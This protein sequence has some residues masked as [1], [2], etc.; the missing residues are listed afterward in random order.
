MSSVVRFLFCIT[1][2]V[3]LAACTDSTA[4]VTLTAAIAATATATATTTPTPLPAATA[5]PQPANTPT[6][7]PVPTDPATPV[8][9]ATPTATA[10]PEPTPTP[11]VLRTA[12]DVAESGRNLYTGELPN[13]PDTLD[14]RA[15]ICKISNF[16]ADMVRPQ[17]GLNSADIIFEHVTEGPIT[18]FSAIF[19]GKTPPN[20]GPIRSARL[21]DLELAVMYDT[22]LCFSGASI[23]VTERLEQ[24]EFRSRLIRSWYPGYY[25]TGA[26]KP[27]EHTFYADP[28]GFYERFE[29]YDKNTPPRP[30]T[31]MDF[32]SATPEGGES[33]EFVQID[34]RGWTVV[35]WRWDEETGKYWRWADGEPI[36]DAND[37]EQVSAENVVIVYA[38]HTLDE[39]ICEHQ[40][41]DK[42]LAGST[43]IHLWGE[44]EMTLLRDGQRFDGYWFRE[45]PTDMLT[46]ESL[47]NENLAL[48]IGNTWVQLVPTH[49]DGAVSFDVDDSFGDSAE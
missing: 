9:T 8:P 38:I 6:D 47:D 42:C 39:T 24:P 3:L 16:P 48:Q 28:A 7:T 44:G 21:V 10:T 45:D 1:L 43:L 17:S 32:E 46:F 33:A 40:Q 4:D 30:T 36:I 18:R 31:Q 5:A 12:A 26:D 49:Y 13:D 19:Y 29:E 20:I 25:R 41:D 34:Y 15:F 11:I 35:E 37:G 14:R 22:S 27:F 2:I 23:G